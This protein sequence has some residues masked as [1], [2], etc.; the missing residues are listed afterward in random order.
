MFLGE[1]KARLEVSV[2]LRGTL[3]APSLPPLP[4]GSPAS[5]QLLKF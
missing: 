4:L 2:Q 5:A 1:I 3:R